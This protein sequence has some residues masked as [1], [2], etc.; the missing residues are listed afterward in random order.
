MTGANGYLGSWVVQRALEHGLSVRA[1]VRDATSARYAWLLAD[2]GSAALHAGQQFTLHSANLEQRGSYDAAFSGASIVFHVA[3]SLHRGGAFSSA[4][5]A[6][7]QQ[8][9][10][11]A[12]MRLATLRIVEST[13]GMTANWVYLPH[14]LL[15]TISSRISNEVNGVNR[16]V[17]D[18]SSKPPSTIEWE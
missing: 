10:L 17:L 4:Q 12:A 5:D 8:Q 15:A 16:V 7:Q 6:Q 13:D 14:E 18:V 1:C 3:A 2:R 11:H 9:Q